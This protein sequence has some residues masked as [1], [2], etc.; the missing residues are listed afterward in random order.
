MDKYKRTSLRKNE[1]GLVSFFV[2]IIIMIILSLVVLGFSQVSRADET[3]SLNKQ[4]S[5]SAYYAA[6]SGINEAYA[7]VRNVINTNGSFIP[8]QS[9]NCTSVNTGPGIPASPPA[10]EYIVS[11]S[12]VLDAGSGTEY[13]CLLVNPTPKQLSFSPNP[14]QSWVV[15][16]QSA[17]NPTSVLNTLNINYSE[18]GQSSACGVLGNNP[19]N[20]VFLPALTPNQM[21][22]NNEWPATCPPVLRIDLVPIQASISSANLDSGVRTFFVYPNTS[23]GTAVWP[24]TNGSTYGS[25]CNGNPNTCNFSLKGLNVNNDYY[26]RLQYIYGSSPTYTIT[27]TDSSNNPISFEGAQAQIELDWNIKGSA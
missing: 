2:T 3:N 12:N 9:N 11:G 6:E 27:G 15:N 21:T 5:L 4:L 18:A 24:L 20:P 13:S 1:S 22:A 19:S 10:P 7:V 17:N 26:M 14:G 16:L 23:A 25:T 8:T